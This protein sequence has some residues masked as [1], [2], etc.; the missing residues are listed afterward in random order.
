VPGTNTP[1]IDMGD[2]GQSLSLRNYNG[3]I[4]LVNK[5]CP[6][7]V[8]IDLNSGHVQLDSTV[9]SGEIVIRGIGKLTDNSGPNA[10]V[11]IQDLVNPRTVADQVWDESLADHS[12]AGTTGEAV[13]RL[14]GLAQENYYLDQ[15]SYDTYNGIKLLTSGRMRV[16]S[17]AGSV[18]TGSDVI[19]TYTITATWNNDELQTYQVVKS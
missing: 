3:G 11:I 8:S 2:V 4:K 16:Y 12:L 18:G 7:P 6:C 10:N 17:Q 14:L 9:T 13:A 5:N 1:I 19:A 15:T